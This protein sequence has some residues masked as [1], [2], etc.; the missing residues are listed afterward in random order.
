MKGFVALLEES[1]CGSLVRDFGLTPDAARNRL[2]AELDYY[3][4]LNLESRTLK[5]IFCRF[6]SSLANRRGMANL[7]FGS[8][9]E[10]EKNQKAYATVL[11]DFDPETVVKQYG[12]KLEQ[13]LADLVSARRLDPKQS[14]RQ[15][16][17]PRA[18][19]RI[20][21]KG[22]LAGAR[23]FSQ[24]EDGT[25]FARFVRTWTGDADMTAMLPEHLAAQGI[26]GFGSALAAD[27][28]KALGVKEL[29][30]PDIWVK[31]CLAVAGIVPE[32]ASAVQV[33]RAF[34]KMWHVL[35][36]N[37]P[38][39]II[40]KFMFLV[41]S[42]RFEMVTPMYLCRSCFAEFEKNVAVLIATGH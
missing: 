12:D 6:C 4:A 10:F 18:Q 5:D 38:P 35:G 37:Y 25:A 9:K 14:E 21:A 3:R 31:R 34:W 17:E 28:L 41:G 2:N 15:L 16:T 23:Y 42:G 39:F 32:T 22:I 30:K 40:D 11:S 7:V 13:L 26:P 36:E 24:Y 27:F 8:S 1:C 33:Q 20:F 19:F 29:G